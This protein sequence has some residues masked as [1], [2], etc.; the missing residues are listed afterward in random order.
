MDDYIPDG[1]SDTWCDVAQILSVNP[2]F[3]DFDD[4]GAEFVLGLIPEFAQSIIENGLVYEEVL[5]AKLSSRENVDNHQPDPAHWM[6]LNDKA[7]QNQRA[8][9]ISAQPLQERTFMQNED[10]MA[11]KLRINLNKAEDVIRAQRASRR[12][13]D[14]AES[15]LK[16]EEALP[17]TRGHQTRI[18]A[19]RMFAKTTRVESA[20]V[21]A[22]RPPKVRKCLR[23]YI[24]ATEV[25]DSDGQS[26]RCEGKPCRKRFCMDTYC[27]AAMVGHMRS[28]NKT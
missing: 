17:G 18:D 6:H 26:T 10:K 23:C 7:V 24:C 20:S 9:I 12:N 13:V 21:E 3:K 1:K 28:H 4:D 14:A 27:Q 25:N 22:G 11:K 16:R 2:H 5:N 15:A 19:A 8:A